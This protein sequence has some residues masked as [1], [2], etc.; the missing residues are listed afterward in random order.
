MRPVTPLPSDLHPVG[1]GQPQLRPWGAT[2][3]DA[4]ARPR[5]NGVDLSVSN[6]KQIVVR[7][8]A[9][10]MDIG[11]LDGINCLLLHVDFDL[12]LDVAAQLLVELAKGDPVL[13]IRMRR[14]L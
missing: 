10:R 8:A 1:V 13:G 3:I 14:R 6:G 4:L 12:R 2:G 11:N 7:F 5:V 9:E